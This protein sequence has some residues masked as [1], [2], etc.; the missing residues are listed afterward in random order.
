MPH[1]IVHHCDPCSKQIEIFVDD[2]RG[3]FTQTTRGVRVS[4]KHYIVTRRHL[5]GRRRSH[6]PLKPSYRSENVD[7][8]HKCDL[9]IRTAQNGG[10]RGERNTETEMNGSKT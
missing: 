9:R 6:V 2:D 10:P 3:R 8:L 5:R 1:H 7:R 4:S